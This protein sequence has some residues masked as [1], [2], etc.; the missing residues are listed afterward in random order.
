MSANENRALTKRVFDALGKGDLTA[1]QKVLG[2]GLREGGAV[3]AKAAK[4]ALPDL[5]ITLEDMI[6][7]G[8]KVVAR[9][10]ATGTHK[11]AGTH[12]FFGQVKGTGKHLNVEGITI[13]RFEQGHVV[14][15]WGLTDEL[16]AAEQLGLVRKSA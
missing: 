9:W 4:T 13:L 6:A 16:G 10:S 2:P 14:E 12:A 3:S 5:R 11:G 15:T 1:A 7:E 8:D